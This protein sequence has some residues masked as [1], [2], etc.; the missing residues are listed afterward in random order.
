MKYLLIPLL[1]MIVSCGN[2]PQMRMNK[3][4]ILRRQIGQTEEEFIKA[5][6]LRKQKIKA[7]D[8]APKEDGAEK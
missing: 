1:A 6:K 2:N 7:Q 8:E 3:D 5:E 4:E